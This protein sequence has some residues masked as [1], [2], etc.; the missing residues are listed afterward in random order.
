GARPARRRSRPRGAAAGGA[1]YRDRDSRRRA[2]ARC[3]GRRRGGLREP[4]ARRRAP[5]PA[6]RPGRQLLVGA[7]GMRT[8]ELALTAS[9]PDVLEADLKPGIEV[10]LRPLGSLSTDGPL[11]LELEDDPLET[12][13]WLPAGFARGET[14]SLRLPAPGTYRLLRQVS[15]AASGD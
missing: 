8:R 6:A 15:S 5:A 13:V 14:I 12:A 11:L 10:E 2:R 4:R 9:L 3:R 1:P 7:A